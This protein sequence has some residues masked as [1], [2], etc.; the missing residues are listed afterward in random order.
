MNIINKKG[1]QKDIFEPQRGYFT[2]QVFDK[3]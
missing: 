3:Y 1:H 2:Q